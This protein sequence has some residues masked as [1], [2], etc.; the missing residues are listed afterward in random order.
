LAGAVVARVEASSE[1][2]HSSVFFSARAMR[3]FTCCV[4][5]KRDARNKRANSAMRCER[6]GYLFGSASLF[7]TLLE[8]L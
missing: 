5:K 3:G 8:Q 6:C 4:L 7:Q 2:L 1:R